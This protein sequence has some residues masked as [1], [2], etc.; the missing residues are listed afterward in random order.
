MQ[1]IGIC[2]AGLI[3]A[4]WAIGFANAGYKSLVYDNNPD[5]FKNFESLFDK[6][7]KDLLIINPEL[8]AEKIKLNIKLNIMKNCIKTLGNRFIIVYCI[9]VKNPNLI[10]IN[11]SYLNYIFNKYM[12]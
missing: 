2:G 5:S 4:S 7:I 1:N 3:G 11:L 6:L 9:F 8:D 10:T 12:L